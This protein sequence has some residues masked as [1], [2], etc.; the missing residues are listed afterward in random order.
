M[1]KITT[2]GELREYLCNAIVFV[3]NGTIDT[4]KARNITK[5]AAQITENV[6]AEAKVAKIQIELGNEAAKF[7]DLSLHGNEG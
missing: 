3:G 7:G 1:A 4:D 5:L 2:S 6:Y